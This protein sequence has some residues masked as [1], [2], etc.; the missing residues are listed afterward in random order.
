MYHL[1]CFVYVFDCV[2]MSFGMYEFGNQ[3][4]DILLYFYVL[5]Y[6]PLCFCVLFLLY[7]FNVLYGCLSCFVFSS[8]VLISVP[9]LNSLWFPF[10]LHLL[11]VIFSLCY[12]PSRSLFCFMFVSFVCL[13]SLFL[14]SWPFILLLSLSFAICLSSRHLSCLLSFSLYLFMFL[15]CLSQALVCSASACVSVSLFLCLCSSRS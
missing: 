2:W 15:L 9:L 6:L 13:S 10:S 3:S 5:I 11:S 7:S 4:F 14:F 1:W 12:N 8:I